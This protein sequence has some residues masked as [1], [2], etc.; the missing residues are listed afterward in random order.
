MGFTDEEKENGLKTSVLSKEK[1]PHQSQRL[2]HATH[3]SYA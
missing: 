1:W 3:A 2:A